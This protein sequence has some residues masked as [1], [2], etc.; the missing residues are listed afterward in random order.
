MNIVV[1]LRTKLSNLKV[2]IFLGQVM[3]RVPYA[4]RPGVGHEY[5]KRLQDLRRFQN[6]S[7]E[8]RKDWIFQGVRNIVE[9]AVVNVPF[10]RSYYAEHDFGIEELR[11]FEDIS[12]I[13]IINKDVLQEFDLA[14]R[15]AR[16][17]DCYLVNTGGSS[18]QTLS[19]YIHTDQ[20]G[21]EWAHMHTIWRKLGYTPTQLK[22]TFGGRSDV[23]NGLEYDFLRH[24]LMVDIYRDFDV[25]ANQLERLLVKYR[26]YYL[27]GYPSALYEFAVAI[28]EQRP[29]LLSDL[30]DDLQGGFLGSEYPM[31][32]YRQVIENTFNIP[33]VSW[34]GHTERCILAYE[35]DE[36]YE[37]YPFQTYGY[38]EV[39]AGEDGRHSLVGTSY[40]NFAS[41]LI[42][43]DTRDYVTSFVNEDS[44]LKSFRIDEGRSGQFIVD[45]NGK[46]IPLTGLIFGRH[47]AIFDN[48]SHIQV[49]QPQPGKAVI[50]FIPLH[51]GWLLEPQEYFDSENVDIKFE[52]HR[53]EQPIRTSSGKINLLVTERDLTRHD[54]NLE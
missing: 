45:R 27:H 53:L 1:L 19:L 42:R 25:V 47:H 31:P 18:G 39:V 37:Y 50:L 28:K 51:D 38:T 16:V 13:P 6:A 10:Y 4:W 48:C 5:R 32:L 23:D 20:V 35:K 46:K 30:A 34:Y 24:S 52:F 7:F 3:A 2:P 15:S 21:N 12:R 41:P 26:V 43:Y 29:D 49:Y 44:M 17:K 33:T 54:L 9:Y 40:H 36:P 22:L 14:S 8:A 11:S